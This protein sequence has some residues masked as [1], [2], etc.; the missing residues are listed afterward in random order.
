MYKV[1]DH[2][3]GFEELIGK[4]DK[5]DDAR[6]A[7]RERFEETDGECAVSIYAL[8]KKGYKVIV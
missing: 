7:A 1:I 5:F 6:A 3:D 2:Y 4:Y 8:T